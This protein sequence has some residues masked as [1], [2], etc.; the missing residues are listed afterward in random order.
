MSHRAVAIANEFLRQ[1][2]AAEQLT[3]MQIQK[4]AY[5]ANG[6]NWAIN[7]EQLISDDPEAWTLG[8][9]YRDLYDHTKFF[10]K[11]PIGRLITPDDSEVSRF[12]GSG[13]REQPPYSA[14]LTQ[15]ERAVIGHVWHRYG[16]LSG[17]RLSQLTHQAGTPWYEAY[18]RGKNSRLDQG[19]IRQHYVELAER[20]S[21]HA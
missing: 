2:G 10:G 8:P 3:Q 14:P 17:V 21:G 4:L 19:T 11:E 15:R 6:W 7:D 18:R 5:I 20:A 16:R 13:K 12:F 1:P 9:V